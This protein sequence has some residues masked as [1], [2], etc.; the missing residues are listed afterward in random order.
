MTITFAV[1][2]L[3]M[4]L[5]RGQTTQAITYYGIGVF[6][7]IIVMGLAVRQ[8]IKQHVVGAARAWG[9]FGASAAAALA[10]L[11]FVGQIV[12]KWEEGSWV[13]LISF[14][15][16]AL[17]AHL[18]LLSPVGH[19]TP[20]QIVTIVRHKAPIQGGMASIVE[21]QSF[22]MQEYRYR[23]HLGLSGFLELFGVGQAYGL[24]PVPAVTPAGVTARTSSLLRGPA[25]L[26]AA[27]W[28]LVARTAAGK[29][30]NAA[31]GRVMLPMARRR[32]PA[33]G[34]RRWESSAC[35]RCCCAVNEHHAIL[36]HAILHHAPSSRRADQR[37]SSGHA[38][39]AGLR[40]F[41][42]R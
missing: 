26:A 23:L 8:H 21:W 32:R 42:I 3:L 1:A 37:H 40:P 25:R 4:F 28:H 38:D 34:A 11:V 29:A 19:R 30:G 41:T 31:G 20:G 10:A 33:T 6:M 27:P 35:A 17:V 39:C 18:V 16:L 36:H 7:P 14:S 22:R 5:V 24:A 2:V 9:M 15:V 12:G 13:V